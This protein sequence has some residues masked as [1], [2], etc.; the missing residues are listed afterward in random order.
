MIQKIVASA[1]YVSDYEMPDQGDEECCSIIP[2]IIENCKKRPIK[3]ILC[4]I[5]IIPTIALAIY[6]VRAISN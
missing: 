1:M 6:V 2:S 3:V 4:L 5:S